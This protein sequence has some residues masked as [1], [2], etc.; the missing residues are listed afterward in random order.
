[1]AESR[2]GATPLAGHPHSSDSERDD[3]LTV[4][5]VAVVAYISANVLHEGLGH[6]GAC[7]LVSSCDPRL[8]TTAY[9][10]SDTTGA[11]ASG[12][13]WLAAGGTLVNAAA[14]LVFLWLHRRAA[15]WPGA[16]RYFLWCSM[17]VNLLVAAGYPLF[18]GAIGVGDWVQVSEGWGPL[19][20]PALT[21]VGLILYLAAVRVALVELASLV[22]TGRPVAVGR[23]VRL[24]LVAYIVGCVA[25]T[26][27]A[28]FNPLGAGL[29]AM[30]AAAHFGGT[31]GLAW[32]PQLLGAAWLPAARV[33]PLRVDRSWA[34]VG[35]ALLALAV[36]VGML[37]RGVSL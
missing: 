8:L 24:T 29:V 37:G 15:G 2:P 31:S 14:G 27:G 9:F 6:G 7:L 16:L 3:L 26:L 34:W 17:S 21:I 4:A 18:S 22:G 33:A 30:S 32:M 11:T 12:L 36:H 10:E 20:R 1:V 13:K 23:G 5:A 19:A 28:L 35:G 25:S